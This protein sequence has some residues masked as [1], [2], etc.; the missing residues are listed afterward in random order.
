MT[1]SVWSLAGHDPFGGAG[2]QADLRVASALS[3]P[4]RTLITSFTAQ[5]DQEFLS[6]EPYPLEW[7]KQQ[8]I[9]LNRA[10]KP[11]AVK[12]GLILGS[13]TI[14]FIADQIFDC[15]LIYDPVLG[16]SSGK[17]LFAPGM[18][19]DLR[20]FLWPKLS[21][22][23]PNLPEASRLVGFEIKTQ[24]DVKRAA[25]QLREQGIRAVLIKGGHAEGDKLYDYFDDGVKS[26]YLEAI[27]ANGQFRGTGCT[28]SSAIACALAKG[29]ELRDAVVFAH[30]Y[31]QAAIHQAAERGDNHLAAVL[32][33][34]VLSSLYY[35]EVKNFDFAR[36]PRA[37]GFYVVAPDSNWVKR[38]ALAKVPTLQLRAKDLAGEDLNQAIDEAKAAC[39]SSGSL[40]FL[41]DHW[42]LG[43]AKKT[44][45]VHLGQEDLD[46]L[47][48]D[49]LESLAA[50]G[51]RLGI[52]TH[53][54][55]EAARAKGINPSY[56]ALGP[57]FETSCKSM[58]FGPQGIPRVGD[59][60]KSLP[61]IPVVAIG[62]LKL[63]HAKDV[64]AYGADGVAV[65]SDVIGAADPESRV[66]DWL[67]T[68]SP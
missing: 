26:F 12:I 37:I 6:A 30:S 2:I 53:S 49:D 62:G 47:S 7:L 55:E 35:G 40:F 61:N 32:N 31:T 64:L 1:G 66:N 29:L 36:M 3:V 39:D 51:T 50:S 20:E 4:L 11:K 19:A 41:N 14:R 27:R 60:V 42:R 18:I 43:M 24:N 13:N 44:F 56:I 54:L 17:D 22:L 67:N 28:L 25:K 58:R 52:S 38:L 65:I 68:W 63:E 5:N 16:S 45:G 23:T 57:V 48:S 8:W 33:P 34:P 46:E 15:P 59:W 10:E 21:L 9:A